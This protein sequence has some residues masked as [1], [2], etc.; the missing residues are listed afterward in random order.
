MISAFLTYALKHTEP[1]HL[2]RVYVFIYVGKRKC[3]RVKALKKETH[4]KVFVFV[5]IFLPYRIR[6][7]ILKN[8]TAHLVGE[9]R[10]LINIQSIRVFTREMLAFHAFTAM[11]Q[12]PT[13]VI[14]T[15]AQSKGN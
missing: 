9:I 13:P 11:R 1:G 2:I 8:P 12:G 4:D 6:R 7:N 5:W 10:F 14:S 15:A 3:L